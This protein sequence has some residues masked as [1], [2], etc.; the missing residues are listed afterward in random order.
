MHPLFDFLLP[1]NCFCCDEAL[2][3]EQR[4]G[5]CGRCWS[6]HHPLGFPVCP[7]CALPRPEGTDLLGPARGRCAACVLSP[8]PFAGVMAVVAYDAIAQAFLLRAKLGRRREILVDLA[9][10]FG[11]AVV[12]TGFAADST[13]VVGTPS[14]PWAT[15]RRG[16]APGTILARE[17]ARRMARPFERRALRHRLGGFEPSKRL[18]AV[19]RRRRSAT[20][21]QS[22]RSLAGERVLLIDDVMT[23]GATA[24]ACARALLRAGAAE[25][26]VAVWARALRHRDRPI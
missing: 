15:V 22:T 4:R 23:T 5:A 12:A 17:V 21:F 18:S 13:I 20:L 14:H 25:V 8:P 9:R 10:L 16:F 19:L 3:C 6:A 2:D 7:T 26:R 24:E 11:A 1:T